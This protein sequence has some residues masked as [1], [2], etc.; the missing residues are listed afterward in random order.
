MIVCVDKHIEVFRCPNGRTEREKELVENERRR[1]RAGSPHRS[2]R[3]AKHGYRQCAYTRCLFKHETR[4][5]A[6]SLVVDDFGI[7]YKGKEHADHLISVLEELYEITTDWTGCKYLG[8]VIDYDR[9]ARTMRLSMPGYIDNAIE[10]FGAKDF[11]AADSPLVYVP[12]AYGQK[13]Q[14]VDTTANDSQLLSKERKT[15]I[16]QIVG[17]LLYYARA[18]DPTMLTAV[19]K[20]SSLQAVPTEAVELAALNLLS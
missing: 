20:I 6:F 16:Q 2:P 19:S 13:Q 17:T 5:V 15:R 18:V 12:P 11:P 9:K 8:I 7:K 4:P 1:A 14:H 10:K 3:L